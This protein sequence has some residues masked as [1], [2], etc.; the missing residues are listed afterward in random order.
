MLFS[1]I[2]KKEWNLYLNKT[3]FLFSHQNTFVTALEETTNITATLNLFEGS[4]QLGT[5]HIWDFEILFL[6]L[7][8]NEQGRGSDTQNSESLSS[9]LAFCF[10]SNKYFIVVW[11]TWK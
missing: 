1:S 3:T 9:S 6:G 2:L 8:L 5:T 11:R 4:S 10:A 7:I